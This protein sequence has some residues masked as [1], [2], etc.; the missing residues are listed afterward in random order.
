MEWIIRNSIPAAKVLDDLID[1]RITQLSIV[2]YDE[3]GPTWGSNFLPRLPHL[4][5]LETYI[6]GEEEPSDFF[7]CVAAS[8]KIIELEFDVSH[9]EMT[10]QDLVRLTQWFQKQPVRKFACFSGDWKAAN[11]RQAF[12]QIMFN[13][14]TLETLKLSTCH[15]NVVDLTE[16][17][18]TMKSL[19]LIECELHLS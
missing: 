2:L 12:N 9:Y 11:T 4:T 10:A 5:S 13:C 8:I 18:L 17:V 15:L 6:V 14:P 3:V 1:G 16:V 19:H 7:E